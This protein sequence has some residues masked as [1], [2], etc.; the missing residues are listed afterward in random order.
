MKAHPNYPWQSRKQYECRRVSSETSTK[1]WHQHA[2]FTTYD[3]HSSYTTAMVVTHSSINPGTGMCEHQGNANRCDKRRNWK[4]DRA[5]H[6][7]QLEVC[8]RN[9]NHYCPWAGGIIRE[10]T[11]EF[12]MQSFFLIGAFRSHWI[13]LEGLRQIFPLMTHGLNS[14]S[15]IF[16]VKLLTANF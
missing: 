13:A 6:C 14:L 12:F 9:M 7:E 16:H 3:R 1:C 11:H 10:T 2:S 8:V 15:R 5:H 4:P